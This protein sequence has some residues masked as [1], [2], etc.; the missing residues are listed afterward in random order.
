MKRRVISIQDV[1]VRI[2]RG[3][4]PTHT[5]THTQSYPPPCYRLQCTDEILMVLLGRIM[6]MLVPGVPC[7]C[8]CMCVCVYMSTHTHT[9]ECNKHVYMHKQHTS[10]LFS[11]SC[12]PFFPTRAYSHSQIHLRTPPFFIC[13]PRL[14]ART[15]IRAHTQQRQTLLLTDRHAR[16]TVAEGRRCGGV[17]REIRPILK[18]LSWCTPASTHEHTPK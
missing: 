16:A 4:L 8:V 18:T 17:N 9:E 7:T 2:D 1:G 13:T 5:H 11:L 15:Q 6:N 3:L 10:V 14:K 12:S